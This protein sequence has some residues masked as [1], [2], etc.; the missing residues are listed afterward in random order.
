MSI[1]RVSSV[2]FRFPFSR[3]FPRIRQPFY[4]VFLPRSFSGADIFYRGNYETRRNRHN[5][6]KRQKQSGK[7][8]GTSCRRRRSYPGQNGYSGQ[9]TRR[10]R[11]K[12]HSARYQREDFR[13][14]R[15]TRQ[16]RV[17]KSKIRRHRL[18]GLKTFRPV[19][20]LR[21]SVFF[22]SQRT[23]KNKSALFGRKE[24]YL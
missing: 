24:L 5:N 19:F 2:Y 14:D 15:Q 6:R 16:N 20:L 13:S 3:S 22:K 7:G 12:R 18:R 17:R 10:L 9:R 11:Y 21:D 23:T 1:R 4:V 8:A